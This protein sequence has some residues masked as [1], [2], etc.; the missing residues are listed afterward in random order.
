M[1]RAIVVP[2]QHF[3][4][5]DNAALNCVIKAIEV[6]KPTMHINI[7]DVGEW[8]SVSAWQW[9]N[10]FTPPLEY[11]VPLIKAE[12]EQVNAGV[13]R[14]D[15][16]LDKVKCKERHI[17]QGNHDLWLDNFY[18]R[19]P[20][21][22]EYTFKNALKWDKRGYTYHHHNKPLKIGKINFIQG[23]YATMYHAK[24]HLD[25]YGANIMYG[26]VHDIQR[27]TLSKLDDGTISAWSIGCI[28]DMASEKNEWL[29]G[30]L[31][32]W[33]HAFAIVTWQKN[34]DFQVEVIDI[35]DGRCYLWGEE[36]RGT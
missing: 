23:V 19:Y 28:K 27:H 11:Q 1:K 6:V 4:L 15:K 10:K 9:K 26:H 17:C 24:K 13:D 20:Y 36:I 5:V 3:P 21:M 7:G 25:A 14:I 30:K 12:I 22:D 8:E 33:R 2:D 29:R 34:G 18:E 16:A 32:N 35:Q 31:T